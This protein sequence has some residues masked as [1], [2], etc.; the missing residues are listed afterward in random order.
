MIGSTNCAA[1]KIR[2]SIRAKLAAKKTRTNAA[3]RTSRII[4]TIAL[5]SMKTHPI[6]PDFRF[7]DFVWRANEVLKQN[8]SCA[9]TDLRSKH[10]SL[11]HTIGCRISDLFMFDESVEIYSSQRSAILLLRWS[12]YEW[13]MCGENHGRIEKTGQTASQ[14]IDRCFDF[15][16]RF[17]CLD[18]I[19]RFRIVSD[20]GFNRL[21]QADDCDR[22]HGR[23]SGRVGNGTANEEQTLTKWNFNGYNPGRI[24]I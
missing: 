15:V 20:S 18:F 4:K 14:K 1:W 7:A 23:F 16:C 3:L 11:K 2:S 13:W 8:G 21:S 12:M 24:D 9:I 19:Y 17:N 22:L 5:V 6:W 10:Y